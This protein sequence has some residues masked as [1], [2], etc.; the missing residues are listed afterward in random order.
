MNDWKTISNSG[1][2]FVLKFRHCVIAEEQLQIM[3]KEPVQGHI[4][5]ACS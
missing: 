2:H 1:K 5:L 4:Y 3:S